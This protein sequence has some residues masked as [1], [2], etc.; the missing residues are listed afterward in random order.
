MEIMS[1]SD[2]IDAGTVLNVHAQQPRPFRRIAEAITT[3]CFPGAYIQDKRVRR[4]EV[5]GCGIDLPVQVV[6]RGRRE[7]VSDNRPP[8]GKC[9]H[10]N[11]Y[12]ARGQPPR[13]SIKTE[14]II[15]LTST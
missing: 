6:G 14:G 3:S 10:P 4:K 8:D 15:R 5:I 1:I 13:A 9:P 12:L 2:D 7:D 11:P